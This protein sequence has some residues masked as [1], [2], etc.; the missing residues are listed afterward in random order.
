MLGMEIRLKVSSYV[1][2]RIEAL[3]SLHPGSYG[4]V[5]IVRTNAMRYLPNYFRR[6]QVWLLEYLNCF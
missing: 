4:N 2:E 1:R 5:S 6:A 3:R